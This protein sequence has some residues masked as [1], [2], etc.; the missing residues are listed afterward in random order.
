MIRYLRHQQIDKQLWDHCIDQATNGIIY[1]YSWYLDQICQG[2]DALVDDDYTTVMPVA[3]GRKYL[4]DYI[5]PPFFAQQLGVFSKKIVTPD[6][7]ESMISAIPAAFR[8]VEMNLHISNQWIPEGYSK[9][10]RTDLILNMNVEY[11]T[12]RN[13]FSEN[14]IRNIKKAEKNGLTIFKSANVAD[15]VNMFRNNRGRYLTN[16]HQSD[17]EMFHKLADEASKR[18]MAKIWMV[19]DKF[20]I[21]CAGAVFFESH[22]TGIFVFSATTG[23]GKE[24]SAMHYLIDHYIREYSL[25]LDKLDFEGSIDNDLARF[26]RGFG[27][28]DYVYLQIKKNQLPLPWKWFKN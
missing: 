15:V 16:L 26:Y 21:P 9:T 25:E 1:A 27:S 19:N 10:S 7:C 14:H 2:W 17:Y 23:N 5:Y 18:G 22:G 6:L 4:M 8:F 11:L 20:G 24:L 12:L 13:S 3:R 28:T